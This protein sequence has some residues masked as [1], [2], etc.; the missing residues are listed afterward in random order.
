LKGRKG[1]DR[2][3]SSLTE[4]EPGVRVHIQL[5]VRK[6]H[7]SWEMIQYRS[8]WPARAISGEH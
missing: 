3:S 4:R 8:L 2:C 5:I 1:Q 7:N 6:D